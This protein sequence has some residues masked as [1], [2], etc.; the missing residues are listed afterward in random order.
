VDALFFLYFFDFL[1]FGLLAFAG[2]VW[3]SSAIFGFCADFF[4]VFWIFY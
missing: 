3:L 1:T 2:F 4:G